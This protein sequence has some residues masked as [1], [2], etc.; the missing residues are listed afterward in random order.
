MSFFSFF[1]KQQPASAARAKDR[2][3]IL[4]AHE[5]RGREQ[6][7]FLPQLQKELLEV[8]KRYVQVSADQVSVQLEQDDHLSVL[9]INVT[10]PETRQE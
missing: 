6:P 3:Q 10:L 9:E 1:Q 8:V 4:L 5:R 7:D 2:L